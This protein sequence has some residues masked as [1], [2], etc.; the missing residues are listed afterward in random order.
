[1]ALLRYEIKIDG[2]DRAEKALDGVDGAAR[3]AAK[4]M[5]A[6]DGASE[7]LGAALDTAGREAAEAERA[8]EAAA[9]GAREAAKASDGAGE[10]VGGLNDKIKGGLAG[11]DEMQGRLGQVANAM[12]LLSGVAIVG[13]VT[14]LRDSIQ[15]VYESTEAGKAHKAQ[16]E[17]TSAAI[18]SVVDWL[19]Q[20]KSVTAA[21]TAATW[22]KINADRAQQLVSGKLTELI[23]KQHDVQVEYAS[24]LRE[25]AILKERNLG[26][27]GFSE[28]MGT[29]IAGQ[30]TILAQRAERLR[31]E[32]IKLNAERENEQASLIAINREV[33]RASR[34]LDKSR[35]NRG[36]DLLE[37][38]RHAAAVREAE[39]A[40]FRL[41]ERQASV[42]SGIRRRGAAVARQRAEEAQAD[43][44]HAEE[45]LSTLSRLRAA[46]AAHAQA[47]VDE[48]ARVAE[49]KAA[50][51]AAWAQTGAAVISSAAS[52]AEALGA[53]A[54]VVAG[55]KIAEN[56]ARAAEEVAL[57]VA[58]AAREDVKGAVVHGFAAAAHVAAAIKW[59]SD[60]LGG[61]GGTASTGGATAASAP[62]PPSS[63]PRDTV[64]A[65]DRQR[66]DLRGGDTYVS[67]NGAPIH[68]RAE[69]QDTIIRAQDEAGKRRT[70]RRAD[71]GRIDS[72]RGRR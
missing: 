19:K 63:P 7:G 57:A 14:G 52:T 4:G 53:S 28:R 26:L 55:L 43:Q 60:A 50:E 10:G 35:G 38:R 49:A 20:Q 30:Q 51:A 21:T 39:E 25:L 22:A 54:A 69:V 17:A 59:G 24:T 56:V 48:A 71:L 66:N 8:F 12:N 33:E 27:D 6:A 40:Y 9:R 36:R 64:S 13:M 68:T 45:A 1:M 18:S 2:A 29:A 42:Q 23:Q 34:L 16:L 67:F 41:V 72:R 65:G 15:A 70:R 58:A 31:D 47:Q 37:A 62:A 5:Q 11:F 3:D 61:G 46:Y 32:L 44:E